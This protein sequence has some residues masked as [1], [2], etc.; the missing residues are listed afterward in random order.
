MEISVSAA[1]GSNLLAGRTIAAAGTEARRRRPIALIRQ[2]IDHAAYSLRT[3]KRTARTAQHLDTIEIVGRQVG[4][5]EA[6]GRASVDVDAVN[7]NEGLRRSRA[8]DHHV[9]HAA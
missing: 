4:H 5:V 8:A 2:H 1:D 3:V 7:E 9:G 6:A